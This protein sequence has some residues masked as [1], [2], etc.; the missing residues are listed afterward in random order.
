MHEKLAE[1]P[2][3]TGRLLQRCPKSSQPFRIGCPRDA[4]QPCRIAC[5]RDAWKSWQP[6]RVSLGQ[7]ILHG[8]ELFMHLW[9]AYPAWLWAFRTFLGQ[10]T[11]HGCQLFKHLWGKLSWMA[12][13]FSSISGTSYPAWLWAFQAALGQ[14]ILHGCEISC[15]AVSFSIISATGWLWSI[16][17]AAYFMHLWDSLSCMAGT[18]KGLIKI[19]YIPWKLIFQRDT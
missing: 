15:M 7:P 1:K 6:C 2:A 18:T 13:S 5:P 16:S 19:A 17:G 8:C 9:A 11:L 14:P 10:A 3:A 12:V 4:W